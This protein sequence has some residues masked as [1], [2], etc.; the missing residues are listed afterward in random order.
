MKISRLTSSAISLIK[1][2]TS[3]PPL[4]ETTVQNT[5]VLSSDVFNMFYDK[6]DRY[7]CVQIQNTKSIVNS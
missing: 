2:V 1:S 4:P 3:V 6:T 5:L 7:C